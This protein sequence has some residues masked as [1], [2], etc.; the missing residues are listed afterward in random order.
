[1]AGA[2]EAGEVVKAKFSFSKKDNK[3]QT[4]I[5]NAMLQDIIR[6]LKA[7]NIVLVLDLYF[8]TNTM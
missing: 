6:L 3:R 2:S 5:L 7:L 4:I 8:S 1:M